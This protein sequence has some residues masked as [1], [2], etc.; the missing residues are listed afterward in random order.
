MND[1]LL[2]ARRVSLLA[3]VAGI[4]GAG[5]AAAA[6]EPPHWAT[7][8]ALQK[9]LNSPLTIM[10]LGNS[11][12]QAV[13]KLSRLQGVAVLIDRR[14]DPDEK[15]DIQWEGVPLWAGLEEI[16]RTA[17]GSRCWARY[18]TWARGGGRAPHAVG[19]AQGGRAAVAEGHGGEVHPAKAMAW[20]VLATPRKLIEK[21]A[22]ENDVEVAGEDL[23]P[24]DPWAAADLPPLSW[25]DRVT[26]IAIQFVLTLRFPRTAR[27]FAWCACRARGDRAELSGRGGCGGDGAEVFALAPAAEVKPSAGRV[28][29]RGLVEDQ[30]RITY[31]GARPCRRSRPPASPWR[32]SGSR[33]L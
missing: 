7:G 30:E 22:A 23:V 8:S 28:Y 26:L 13:G 20:D 21:L 3:L 11:L 4:L 31:R 33:S 12:R 6:R 27:R 16:A 32:W 5:G 18:C 9:R 2:F 25:T 14:V 19:P 29:V 17:W 1:C 10:L 15:L 24:H